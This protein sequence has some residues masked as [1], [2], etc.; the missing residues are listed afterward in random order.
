MVRLRWWK[1]IW[2]W[3]VALFGRTQRPDAIPGRVGWRRISSASPLRRSRKPAWV[4]DELIRLTALMP[5]TGCRRIAQTFN[6]LHTRRRQMTVSKSFVAYTLRRERHAVECKRRELRRRKAYSP[7]RN[8]VWALDMTG[9][10]DI[11]GQQHCLLGLIDHGTRRLLELKSLP[12]KSAWT[13]LGYLFLSIGRYGKPHA[14]RTDNERIFT[15][16]VF[17]Q[18]LK[19]VGIRH[20]RSEVGCPWQN[21]RIERLFCTLKERLD[22]WRVLDGRQLQTALQIFR[23]W[24]NAVRPHQNLNGRTP[25]EA[26][27]GVDPY[28][29][30]PKRVEWFEAWDGLLTGFYLDG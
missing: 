6:R 2:R 11:H 17:S 25:L 26:W 27:N 29:R 3:L 30:M 9:K 23:F 10:Q 18:V 22:Q 24:Y 21:G 20:Q 16:R 8:A 15:G 7:N 13:L 5:N 1:A 19:W 12:N 28:Q 14:L 4:I